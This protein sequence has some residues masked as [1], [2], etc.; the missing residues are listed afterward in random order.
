[1]AKRIY[2]IIDFFNNVT[3]HFGGEFSTKRG[4][5]VEKRRFGWELST[6]RGGFVEK[7][8]FG[9]ELSTKNCTV[10]LSGREK[11]EKRKK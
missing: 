10:N 6:K 7:R 5:F 1:M 8:C 11:S 4:G 3:V 9:Q 2:S